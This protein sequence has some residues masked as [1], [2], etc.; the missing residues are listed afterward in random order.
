[1]GD[2]CAWLPSP[3]PCGGG[4]NPI[5]AATFPFLD[6]PPSRR[7]PRR[8]KSRQRRWL[9]VAAWWTAGDASPAAVYSVGVGPCGGRRRERRGCSLWICWRPRMFPVDL[10]VLWAANGGE[11]SPRLVDGMSFGLWW[12]LGVLLAGME[13]GQRLVGGV[14][15][16]GRRGRFV[17]EEPMGG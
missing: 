5:S 4:G 2:T 10:L 12:C 7:A 9:V 8:Q 11:G 14:L 6:P 16:V 15:G 3:E 13:A 1:M 17:L